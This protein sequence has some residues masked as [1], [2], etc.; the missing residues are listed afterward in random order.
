MH[1]C[2]VPTVRVSPPEAREGLTARMLGEGVKRLASFKLIH[3]R[4]EVTGV[5]IEDG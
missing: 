1:A 4:H 3:R 5:F 2:T